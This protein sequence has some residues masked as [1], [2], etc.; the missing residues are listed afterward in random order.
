MT[1]HLIPK[2]RPLPITWADWAWHPDIIMS[3]AR[4][5]ALLPRG[6]GDRPGVQPPLLAGGFRSRRQNRCKPVHR[7]SV[8][9]PAWR[10]GFTLVELLVVISII[11]I[12]AAMLLP[13]L[14]KVKVKGQVLKAR[15]D[16]SD[17]V[18]GCS[19]YE[20]HYSRLPM[21]VAAVQS[22]SGLDLDFTFGWSIGGVNVESPGNY[23]SNNCEVTAILLDL[24]KYGD[25][26]PT[27]N[28]GHV[29]N[30]QRNVYLRADTVS[31][32]ASHGVGLDG[33]FRDP[34][35][36]PYIISMDANSD[37]KVRDAF[38][39]RQAVSQ[40]N[41]QTGLNGLFNSRDAGGNGDNFEYSGQVMAWS[42]GPDKQIDLNN[43][44]NQGLN[45]DNILSWKP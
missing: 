33:T 9:G 4:P 23:K 11:A 26:R 38:Y 8:R 41:G 24:E 3:E 31:D 12:L 16:I 13:V 27:I 29:K 20:T 17:L 28:S 18:T 2:E 15:K 30:T 14:T 25:G 45:K 21:S 37:D 44:A 5:P 39:C 19:S 43:K 35:G 6:R 34:W 22:V 32:T 7:R 10:R 1:T 42:A 36:N 40:A